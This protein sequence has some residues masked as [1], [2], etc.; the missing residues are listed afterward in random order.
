MT[1]IG[2]LLCVLPTDEEIEAPGKFSETEIEVS[3]R[4]D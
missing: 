2:L 4:W 3:D 1:F